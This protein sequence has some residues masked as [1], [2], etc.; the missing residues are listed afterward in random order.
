MATVSLPGEM[1][2]C[3]NCGAD[4]F[5]ARRAT[6]GG[7]WAGQ[8]VRFLYQCSDCKH[9][10]LIESATSQSGIALSGLLLLA[11]GL[12]AAFI[13]DAPGNL[14]AAVV[15]GLL[16][17]FVVWQGVFS[18]DRKAPIVASS[19]GEAV[20]VPI[21]DSI[22]RSVE[23][24]KAHKRHN[25]WLVMVVYGLAGLTLLYCFYELMLK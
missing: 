21:E 4:Q 9:Q 7:S 1:R 25:R 5:K 14:I 16:G 18:F 6:R 13:L 19:T 8:G 10:E 17:G 2:Q 24:E 15:L 20:S 22:F 23:E 3:P 11:F 12:G